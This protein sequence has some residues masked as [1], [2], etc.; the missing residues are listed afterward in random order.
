MKSELDEEVY[1]PR[2]SNNWN[3]IGEFDNHC[4]ASSRKDQ[5]RNIYSTW[6]KAIRVGQ[7]RRKSNNYL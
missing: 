1:G 6:L 7:N 5:Q 2:H 4:D 3:A